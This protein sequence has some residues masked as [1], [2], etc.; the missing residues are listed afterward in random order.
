ML[1][2]A[3]LKK[4]EFSH[5]IPCQPSIMMFHHYYQQEQINVLASHP[6]VLSV[7]SKFGKKVDE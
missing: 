6:T 3:P 2:G 1:G 5:L 7:L 4:I